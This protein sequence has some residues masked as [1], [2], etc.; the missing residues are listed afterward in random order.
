MRT[1]KQASS[2]GTA[3]IRVSNNFGR[4]N[5]AWSKS[6]SFF[7]GGMNADVGAGG[8]RGAFGWN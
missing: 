3:L 6:L 1:Q 8:I 7:G 2:P 4:G 5:G